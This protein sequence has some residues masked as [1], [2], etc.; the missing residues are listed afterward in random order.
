MNYKLWR[1]TNKVEAQLGDEL[2]FKL[3]QIGFR[4]FDAV[5]PNIFIY[6]AVEKDDKL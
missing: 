6:F 5:K 4:H 3:E 1:R 2:K